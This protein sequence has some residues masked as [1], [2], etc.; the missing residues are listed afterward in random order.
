MDPTYQRPT[1]RVL[2]LFFRIFLVFCALKIKYFS[3][4]KNLIALHAG[5]SLKLNFG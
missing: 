3:L 4:A 1:A 5:D 2:M